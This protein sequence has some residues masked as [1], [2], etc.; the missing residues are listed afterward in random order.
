M[1][2]ILVNDSGEVVVVNGDFKIGFSN[3][4]HKKHLLLFEKGSIK[5]NPTACVGAANFLENE[6]EAALYREINIQFAGDGM[7]VSKIEV[8]NSKIIVDADYKE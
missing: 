3:Q 2:D 8:Q 1:Q 6:D 4:Q 7:E 5:E